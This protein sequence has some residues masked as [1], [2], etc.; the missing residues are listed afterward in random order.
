[1]TAVDA[2]QPLIVSCEWCDEKLLTSLDRALYDAFDHAIDTHRA[3][4]LAEP[5]KLDQRFTVRAA[6]PETFRT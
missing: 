5:E 1:M 3:V 2:Q 4:L 6:R